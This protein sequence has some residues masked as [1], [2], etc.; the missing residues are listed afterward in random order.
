[1]PRSREKLRVFSYEDSIV[2]ELLDP[3]TEANPDLEIKTATFDSNEEAAAKL[4]GG[5]E[6]D[7][8]EICLDEMKPLVD[9]GML[10]PLDVDGL[11]HWDD[12]NYTEAEGIVIDDEIY[13]VP[14]SAGLEGLLYNPED[15]PRKASTRMPTFLTPS[16]EGRSTIQGSYALLPLSRPPRWPSGSRTR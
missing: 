15:G 9:Q 5:F 7:V 16:F 8:V 11:V 13:G 12:L 6:V 10:R 14:L 4:A 2:P 3:V 1:M